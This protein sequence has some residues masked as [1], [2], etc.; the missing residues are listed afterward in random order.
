MF[1]KYVYNVRFSLAIVPKIS[2]F[3]DTRFVYGVKLYF[4]QIL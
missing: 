3:H 1:Y 4:V 2:K